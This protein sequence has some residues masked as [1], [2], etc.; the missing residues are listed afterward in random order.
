M[1]PGV[2]VW[3]LNHWPTREVPVPRALSINLVN[4]E[5]NENR[6]SKN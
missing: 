3:S 2:E 1:A 4:S 5:I 6:M